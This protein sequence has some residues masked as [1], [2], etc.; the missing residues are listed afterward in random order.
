MKIT[1]LKTR[2]LQTP[3]DSPLVVGLP[4]MDDRQFVTLEL[5]TDEG[6]EGIGITFFGGPLTRALREAVEGLGSLIIG[7]DPIRV[8]AIAD[9]LWR[10]ASGSGP[11]G[12]FTLALSAIDIALWDIKGKAL[13]MPVCTLLGGHR[14]RVP[15]YASG[16]LMRPMPT[17]YLREAGPRL[18]SMGFKQMKTQMGAEPTVDKEIERIRVLREGI[19][20]NIDLM[21]DIN[22]LWNVNQ[23]IDIGR[24]VEEYHLFWL[25]DVVAHDDFQG[26]ARVA[27]A[28]TTPICAGEY[29]Y[30]IRP[31]RHMLEAR[32]I[33][34]VMIDLLRAGGIT[35][36]MK[37]AG[38]AEAFNVP[39]V[40][41]LIPEI[42]VHLIA[43]IPHGLTVEYMPWTL[44]LFEE[45]P[46]IE[47]GQIVVPQ[48]PGLG[49]K[50]DEGAL[51]QFEIS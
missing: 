7:D 43:A 14:D 29:H 23:A 38:M 19:G 27:D 30:G 24:R 31:F 48:K 51:R 10:A 45:T 49:L 33:D 28:L 1:Q 37:I 41:H 11:G 22:Q 40:S 13:N 26:L 15:T 21:C 42:H 12:I 44:R 50:F 35:Q 20:E 17:D 34:I 39:V 16:A 46:A 8:E 47:D 18:V 4:P 2:V 5:G 9:K 25:E 6:I 32:S 36:W 3:G